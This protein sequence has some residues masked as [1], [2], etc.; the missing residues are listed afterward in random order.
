MKI[1]NMIDPKRKIAIAFTDIALSLYPRVAKKFLLRSDSRRR[2]GNIDPSPTRNHEKTWE[3]ARRKPSVF[4][5]RAIVR[6][7]SWNFSFLRRL[8]GRKETNA[9]GH[10][11][12]HRIVYTRTCVSSA[13]FWQKRSWSTRDERIA[14]DP[15][16]F[17]AFLRSRS[18]L[19][20]YEFYNTFLRRV[21]VV[22]RHTALA[23]EISEEQ[24]KL[25]SPRTM[26]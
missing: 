10:T 15:N 18:F 14:K 19:I 23:T 1:P 25:I 8:R 12:S 17:L 11:E 22:H 6:I 9:N 2:F 26:K 3:K 21:S 24:E 20:T 7:Q 13:P 5:F 4:Y 16:L